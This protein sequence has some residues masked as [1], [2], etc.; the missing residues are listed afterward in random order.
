M[1]NV[2][3][4]EFQQEYEEMLLEF[5][6]DFKQV[7]QQRNFPQERL[8]AFFAPQAMHQARFANEQRFDLAG[9]RGRL[10]SSSY[11][12]REGEAGYAPMLARLE[13]LFSQH[14]QAGVVTFAYVVEVYHGALG[15]QEAG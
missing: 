3:G 7:D 10:L 1:R 13:H 15:S 6:T 2:Q 11:A 12:P 4:S 9:L 5:G 8:A 14:Q